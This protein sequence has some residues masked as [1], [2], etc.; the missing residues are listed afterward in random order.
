MRNKSGVW[1]VVVGMLPLSWG[2]LISEGLQLDSPKVSRSHLERDNYYRKVRHR[3]LGWAMLTGRKAKML[4]YRARSAF[5]LLQIEEE[6]G[7][8]DRA[9][10]VVDLCAGP[11]DLAPMRSQ[12]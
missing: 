2:M 1:V 5:K 3:L 4:G 6:F 9:E 11:Q 8:L 10:C 12:P 7:L